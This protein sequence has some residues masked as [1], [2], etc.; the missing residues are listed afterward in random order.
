MNDL[1]S[2]PRISLNVQQITSKRFKSIFCYRSS[3]GQNLIT[4]TYL[5]EIY[6]AV[7]IALLGLVLFGLLIGNMQV[8][9]KCSTCDYLII[10][11]LVRLS[12]I[13]RYRN[14]NCL[15]N[16]TSMYVCAQNRHIYSLLLQ[17][18]KSGG[19]EGLTPNSGCITGNFP[20]S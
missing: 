20:M 12:E 17:D 7:A 18:W 10:S 11:F 6:F 19:L 13:S 16:I 2:H 5:S 1:I 14:E 8:I 3:L 4:S 9:Q 15:A